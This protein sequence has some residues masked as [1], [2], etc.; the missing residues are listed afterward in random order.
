MRALRGLPGGREGQ[1]PEPSLGGLNGTMQVATQC[2]G[3]NV[4]HYHC[5]YSEVSE[6]SKEHQ[7]MQKGSIA[8]RKHCSI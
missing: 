5:Y 7:E 1:L 3:S 8:L 4:R 2:G 6:W